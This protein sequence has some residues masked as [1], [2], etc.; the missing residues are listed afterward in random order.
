MLSRRQLFRK[1]AVAALGTAALAIVPSAGKAAMLS[2]IPSSPA[3]PLRCQRKWSGKYECWIVTWDYSFG[4]D[5]GHSGRKHHVEYTVLADNET[6]ANTE[7]MSWYHREAHYSIART[8]RRI[9]AVDP[10]PIATSSPVY[11]RGRLLAA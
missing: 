10:T 4:E 2:V 11:T 1:G 8:V 3:Q 6:L 9:L 5:Y 7:I